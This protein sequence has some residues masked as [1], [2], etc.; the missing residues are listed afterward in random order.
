MKTIIC[1]VL[2]FFIIPSVWSFPS[3]A[4]VTSSVTGTD[5][6]HIYDSEGRINFADIYFESYIINNNWTFH[7]IQT[8]KLVKINH[9]IVELRV[10]YFHFEIQ[11]ISGSW[12]NSDG[13]LSGTV[14]FPVRTVHEH[15][16]LDGDY[17]YNQTVIPPD[18]WTGGAF[19]LSPHFVNLYFNI[20]GENKNFEYSIYFS[21]DENGLITHDIEED[22]YLNELKINSLLLLKTDLKIV[23][24]FIFTVLG[25]LLIISIF[26]I[27]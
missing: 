2:F 13:L 5:I 16:L 11:K 4:I 1:L 18:Y 10:D 23:L 20:N 7:V 3:D 14:S 21:F 6:Y 8:V 26:D 9:S 22:K 12:E 27:Y 24:Y 19:R 17:T 25:T 15:D